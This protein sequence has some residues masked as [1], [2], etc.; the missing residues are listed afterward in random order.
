MSRECVTTNAHDGRAPS[1]GCT[2]QRG[3]EELLVARSAVVH[4][5]HPCR[6]G[7]PNSE[8]EVVCLINQVIVLSYFTKLNL[9]ISC[10]A[11]ARCRNESS[12]ERVAKEERGLFNV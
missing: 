8:A 12:K 5:A 3:L 9:H 6:V 4:V 10:F 1:A 7:A 2:P 11:A